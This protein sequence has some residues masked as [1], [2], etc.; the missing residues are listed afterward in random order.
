MSI[1]EQH[2]QRVLESKY[3]L[4]PLTLKRLQGEVDINYLIK[5]ADT[6][7]Y[8]FKICKTDVP[9]EEVEF[10]V[11][12]LDWMKSKEVPFD[13]PEVIKTNSGDSFFTIKYQ[14]Q[15]CI[16]R[17]HSWVDGEML[18]DLKH[19]STSL[20]H[21]WGATCGHL[22][23]SLKGF[24]HAGA[25]RSDKWNPVEVLDSKPYLSDIEDDS[26]RQLA[27]HFFDLVE[28]EYLSRD[29]DLRHSV[30]YSDAHEHNL[31][32]QD[33]NGKVTGVIDF[34]DA[35]YAPTICEL[36]IACAYAG[37]HKHDPIAAMSTVISGCHDVFPLDE[38]EIEALYPLICSRLLITVCNAAHSLQES[39]DDEYLQI[40]ADPAWEL[41]GRLSQVHHR[42]VHYSFRSA[43]GL[44]PHPFRSQ[45]DAW[46]E[47]NT[48]HNP[49]LL[50]NR[51]LG[52]LDLSVGSTELGN[53]DH[54]SSIP[55]FDRRIS[56]IMSERELDIAFGGYGEIRPVYTTDAY[57]TEG[58]NGPQWR[59]MHLGKDYWL[60]AGANVM[61]VAD[62]TVVSIKN[63]S[64]DR[65]YGPTIILQHRI[66]G[67]PKFYSLYGHLSLGALELV[68][69]GQTVKAGDVIGYI[70][71]A[72]VNGGWPPHLHFQLTLDLL[73]NEG[74]FPGV[75]YVHERKAWLSLCPPLSFEEANE[76]VDSDTVK[77]NIERERSK[78]LSPSLST[79]YDDHLHIVRGAGQY[80]YDS[81]GR[82]YLDMVNNVAHVGHEHPRVVRAGASQMGVLNT[83]TRYLHQN[84]IDYANALLAKCPDELDTVFFVN[85]GSEANEL[86]LRIA[87]VCSKG[88]QMIALQAGYHGN[89]GGTVGVS[90]YKFDG[91]GGSGAPAN[92]TIIPMP[93][94]YRGECKDVDV[95]GAY[96]AKYIEEAV[97]Q[98]E[99]NQGK[100]AGFLC[101]SILSCGGQIV[102]PDGYLRQAYKT[103]RKAG[104][105]CIAD[106]VQVGFGRVGKHFWGFQLQGVVP[107]IITCG[108][109]IGNGHP[110]AA[111]VTTSDIA[112]QF[113]NGMEYFNTYGGNPV[114]CAIGLE[115]LRVIEDEKLQSKALEVGQHLINGLKVLRSKYPIIGD[116]RGVGLF[117]G[118]ELVRAADT[119]EPADRETTY[120]ANRMR[121]LGILCSTDGPL[122]NVLK[123]KPPLCIT[124]ENI[125]EFLKRLDQVLDEVAQLF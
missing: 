28:D 55:K 77:A 57:K 110:L 59:T 54:F 2:L 109:P 38:V 27:S 101:E 39:P 72:N 14:G 12:L 19:R 90:S 121:A 69:V 33:L 73:G 13:L 66:E 23:L 63:N 51:R 93:D 91:K 65:D 9:V 118:I 111:V 89:T 52:R 115:V 74:N 61:A 76:I 99:K 97:G 53:D 86:A 47:N 104:G 48:F 26:M 37:M 45:F 15:A 62:G 10:Q 64:I 80:L 103:V 43:V 83:N 71:D 79:S 34:G 94:V 1:A 75:A 31:L 32:L 78:V 114:S 124:V 125:D 105:L 95:A 49:V 120:I 88:E 113:A 98:I 21:S 67:A 107:D 42:F 58:N 106:E 112:K 46:R 56:H 119:Y 11:A 87:K 123:F 24:D 44:D 117:S 20:L 17:L 116:V 84:I 81:N 22:S 3:C 68:A 7:R 25:H 6:H 70:G 5:A 40:S 4:S 92:T 122:H 29:F 82:R 85:S 35:I 50:N 96:Y 108:K 16:A 102:L 30:N 100:V 8:L 60:E 41:L 36:A 18:G